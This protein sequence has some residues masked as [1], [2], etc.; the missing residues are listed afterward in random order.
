MYIL[1]INVALP[2]INILIQSRSNVY[3]FIF[4][5]APSKSTSSLIS[6]VKRRIVNILVSN[7]ALSISPSTIFNNEEL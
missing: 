5:V 7:V 6:N 4:N 2:K 3:I 1:A